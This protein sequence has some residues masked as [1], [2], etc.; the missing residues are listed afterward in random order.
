MAVAN[1]RSKTPIRRANSL[2]ISTN[3]QLTAASRAG[4]VRWLHAS[5]AGQAAVPHGCSQD[6]R[7]ELGRVTVASALE[8]EPWDR[9]VHEVD[10]QAPGLAN[11]RRRGGVGRQR[12]HAQIV[13]HV[14]ELMAGTSMGAVRHRLP[15]VLAMDIAR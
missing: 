15:A 9:R 14:F 13:R 7:C 8:I 11:S 12:H 1:V 5:P 3:F 6:Y 2:S 4:L 10:G